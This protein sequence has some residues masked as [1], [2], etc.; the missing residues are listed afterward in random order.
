MEEEE[1]EE[2]EDYNLSRA[3]I[4]RNLLE[5]RRTFWQE[6]SAENPGLLC[7]VISSFPD[8][9]MRGQVVKVHGGR[10]ELT[11][12]VLTGE[13]THWIYGCDPKN[14]LQSAVWLFPN[15]CILIPQTLLQKHRRSP[16]TQ[17]HTT[18]YPC[19]TK[20]NTCNC[21]TWNVQPSIRAMQQK[22]KIKTL[23]TSGV[24]LLSVKQV[25]AWRW[26]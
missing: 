10:W 8:R 1:E 24:R 21:F 25:R 15:V 5:I 4:K 23:S 20:Q 12:E 26:K 14:K 13:E 7:K 6:C 16:F 11:W 3:Y 17:R 18:P 9:Q 19:D 2:E 22:R